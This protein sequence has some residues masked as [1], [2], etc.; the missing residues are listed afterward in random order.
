MLVY[1]NHAPE[2]TAISAKQVAFRWLPFF[3]SLE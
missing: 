1:L 3:L 2:H